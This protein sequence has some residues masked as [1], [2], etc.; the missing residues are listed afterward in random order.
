MNSPI[1]LTTGISKRLSEN[2]NHIAQGA[3]FVSRRNNFIDG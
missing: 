1:S 2:S 3:D